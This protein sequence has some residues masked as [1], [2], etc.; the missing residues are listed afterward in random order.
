M[1]KDKAYGYT[2]MLSRCIWYLALPVGKNWN[3]DIQQRK[4]KSQSQIIYYVN[5]WL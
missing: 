2:K 4:I 5:M 3:S 1:D